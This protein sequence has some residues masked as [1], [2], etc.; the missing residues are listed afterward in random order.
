[1]SSREPAADKIRRLDLRGL[2]CPLPVLKIR[3]ALR[4]MGPGAELS[5]L[6][7]DPLAGVDVPNLVRETGDDLVSTA[8]AGPMTEFVIRRRES[9]HSERRRDQEP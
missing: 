1:M 5:A 2:R 4:G 3:K 6:C 7:D 8:R 9:G